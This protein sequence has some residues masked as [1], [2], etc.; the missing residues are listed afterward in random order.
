MSDRQVSD[1]DGHKGETQPE[2]MGR[3]KR[4]EK[5]RVKDEKSQGLVNSQG[6]KQYQSIW[7]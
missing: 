5:K 2:A 6:V 1:K 4:G 7:G 3:K